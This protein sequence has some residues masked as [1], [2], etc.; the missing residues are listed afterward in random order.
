MRSRYSLTSFSAVRL[1]SLNAAWIPLVVSAVPSHGHTLLRGNLPIQQY[2]TADTPDD[3]NLLGTSWQILE[4]AFDDGLRPVL[5]DYPANLIFSNDNTITAYAGCNQF[6][7]ELTPVN[8]STFEV[9]DASMTTRG[10]FGNLHDQDDALG[11][12][13]FWQ[14]TVTYEIAST[15]ENDQVL[16]LFGGDTGEVTARLVPLP[17]PTLVGSKWLVNGVP[18]SWAATDKPMTLTFEDETKFSGYGGCN[19]FHGEWEDI[20]E[21]DGHPL[22]RTT[23]F[24][25]TKR[26][27]VLP[28]PMDDEEEH[29]QAITE[30]EGLLFDAL[31]QDAVAYR[32]SSEWG[33]GLTL[34]DT[35]IG[36]SDDNESN[37]APHSSLHVGRP[38]VRL[39]NYTSH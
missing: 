10:C 18:N 26:R 25:S 35:A 4:I 19:S 11:N 21:D 31:N 17:E 7:G 30:Q 12:A 1:P 38:L 6:Q 36:D 16:T 27:C 37:D 9:S 29:I 34:Y 22:F 15:E 2:I 33:G 39:S 5:E 13:I 28:F 8:S 14:S 32:I 23:N 3:N 24:V 20:T